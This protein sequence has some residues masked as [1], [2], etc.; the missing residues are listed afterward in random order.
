MGFTFVEDVKNPLSCTLL[1]KGPNDHTIAQVKDAIRDGLRAVVNAI[2]DDA[3]VPGAGA[4]EVAAHRHL[5]AFSN[6]VE[7]KAKIGVRCFAD[8]LLVIPRTLASNAG[9][10]PDDVVMKLIDTQHKGMLVGMDLETGEP[11]D[12]VTKGILDNVNVKRQMI[13]SAGGIANQLLMVDE[14]LKAGAARGMRQPGCE[15]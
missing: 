4:F 5:M 6:D 7:G 2:E 14:I 13:S 10:D 8:S 3:V 1:V 9:L 11:I 12:P 15:D